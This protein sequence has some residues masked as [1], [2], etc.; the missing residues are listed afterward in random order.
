MSYSLL[1]IEHTEHSA[2]HNEGKLELECG[3][4][5]CVLPDSAPGRE[6]VDGG[7]TPYPCPFDLQSLLNMV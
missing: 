4:I 3:I 6:S 1:H 5:Y 2:E 7:V